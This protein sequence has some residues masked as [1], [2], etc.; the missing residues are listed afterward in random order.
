[1]FHPADTL[2]LLQTFGKLLGWYGVGGVH[3]TTLCLISGIAGNIAWIYHT[4]TRSKVVVRGGQ[5]QGPREY[6]SALGASGIVMGAGT[7]AACL[8]PFAPM[9]VFLI[10]VR[11]PLWGVL[12]GYYAIDAYFLSSTTSRIG[13]A[14]HLGGAAAGAAYYLLS[15]RGLGGVWWM[16]SRGG[17]RFR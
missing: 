10:P 6:A 15:L 17:R 1:M 5:I 11:L 14:A 16:M 12:A 2:F 13:H 7:V 4:A 3:I 8:A 9:S